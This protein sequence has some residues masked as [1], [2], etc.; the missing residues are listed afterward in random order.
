M[1]GLVA[2]AACVVSGLAAV[3]QTMAAPDEG[4]AEYWELTQWLDTM[5]G[6]DQKTIN[7]TRS[8]FTA[9]SQLVD[10]INIDDR[11]LSFLNL[12]S[13]LQRITVDGDR[14]VEEQVADW[15]RRLTVRSSWLDFDRLK[16][17]RR[18]GYGVLEWDRSKTLRHRV[19]NR[20]RDLDR[21][22]PTGEGRRSVSR[23][24]ARRLGDC[25]TYYRFMTLR[26]I[27]QSMLLWEF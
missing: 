27:W 17:S 3:P 9:R 24:D 15:D 26:E 5:A 14:T 18:T 25:P 12:G 20:W 7:R 8:C 13:R 19:E 22:R 4:E 16:V 21:G 23:L 1:K 2:V 6:D 11:P 10:L